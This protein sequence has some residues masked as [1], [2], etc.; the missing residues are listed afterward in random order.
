MDTRAQPPPLLPRRQ[1]FELECGALAADLLFDQVAIDLVGGAAAAHCIGRI[2]KCL[3]QISQPATA[4]S[5]ACAAFIATF[6]RQ[7]GHLRIKPGDDRIKL[8]IARLGTA[9]GLR[10]ERGDS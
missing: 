7:A 10:L 1:F 8:C 3:D 2:E 6:A 4:R 9:S 5:C